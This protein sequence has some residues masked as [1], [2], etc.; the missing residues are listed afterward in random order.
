MSKSTGRLHRDGTK[1]M[2][3]GP[4][5]P[6]PPDPR[7]AA[8]AGLKTPAEMIRT[9]MP[10][11]TV[12]EF[13]LTGEQ[14]KEMIQKIADEYVLKTVEV[15]PLAGGADPHQPPAAGGAIDMARIRA[16]PKASAR[17]RPAGKERVCIC[18]LVIDPARREV[19]VDGRRIELTRTLFEVLM[20]LARK[21]GW[22]F[23]HFQIIEAV[24]G[25]E[26]DMLPATL[27][28][29]ISVLRRKLGPA[30]SLIETLPAVGYRL[31]NEP[32]EPPGAAGRP[33]QTD[34]PRR[35]GSSTQPQSDYIPGDSP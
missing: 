15:L 33:G 30:G 25:M 11:V 29:H 23:S 24:R 21:P 16:Y 7:P 9:R 8:A 13:V 3:F 27:R 32:I 4:R 18:N 22:V 6:P 10:D 35:T 34:R 19:H 14:A 2:T 1:V 5:Q 20:A 31:N 12:L 28:T 17:R 26:A